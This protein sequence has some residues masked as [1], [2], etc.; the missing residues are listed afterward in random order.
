MKN[1]IICG[2]CLVAIPKYISAESIDLM[3]GG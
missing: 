2:D 3:D 1:K